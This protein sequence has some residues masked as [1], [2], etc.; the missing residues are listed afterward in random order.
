MIILEVYLCISVLARDQIQ[1]KYDNHTRYY[2]SAQLLWFGWHK[3][4]WE[5][6]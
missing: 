4:P 6:C 2:P 5:W 1:M 3:D